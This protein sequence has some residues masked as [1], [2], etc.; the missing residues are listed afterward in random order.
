MDQLLAKKSK[1]WIPRAVKHS[2][3]SQSMGRAHY[4]S[5]S[6]G[7]VIILS[8]SSI[9]LLARSKTGYR[10]KK[11]AH[12]TSYLKT[13]IGSGRR[14]IPIWMC[15]YPTTRRDDIRKS[16]RCMGGFKLFWLRSFRSLCQPSSNAS[17][18]W[19]I[20]VPSRLPFPRASSIPEKCKQSYWT[21]AAC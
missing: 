11:S 15:S 16:K 7:D 19:E 21:P 6:E 10:T 12:G 4:H 8:Y 9:S 1:V 20:M 5:L 13:S 3:R 17:I 14:R 2:D 18:K